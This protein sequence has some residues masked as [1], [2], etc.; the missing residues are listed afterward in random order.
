DEKAHAAPPPV[1]E[2]R[3]PGHLTRERHGSA[4]LGEI[5][6]LRLKV[7]LREPST[8]CE[9]IDDLDLD[10][11]RF[12]L[13]ADRDLELERQRSVSVDR[14][15]EEGDLR[16]VGARGLEDG[17]AADLRPRE[18]RLADAGGGRLPSAEG[19]ALA[20][21][22]EMRGRRDPDADRSR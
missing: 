2:R 5:D 3:R 11:A 4:V 10:D 15:S 20:G 19:D 8:A 21:K 9:G 7:D 18:A 13:L 1:L 14:R 16:C 12:A 17:R 6:V 22:D